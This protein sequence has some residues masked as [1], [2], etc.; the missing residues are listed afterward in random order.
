MIITLA[1]DVKNHVEILE[2]WPI[3][4]E[5]MIFFLEREA[6]VL[7]RVCISFSKVGI[8]HAPRL[9]SEMKA[10]SVP[11]IQLN[12]SGYAASARARIMNW[13]AV[14]SGQQ[15]VDIDY[16]NY[17]IRFHAENLGEER[18]IPIKSFK[19]S[20]D[21]ALNFACDFEQIGRAFCVGPISDDRI[22]STSHF[23][24]G[25]IAFGAGRYVDSYNNM[26]LFLETRYCDG[27]TK[28]AQQIELLSKEKVF[29]ESLM[30]TAAEF[31]K[32]SGTAQLDKFD[33]F[34][35]QD[36]IRE[37][38]KVLV[39]LRGNLRHHS[40]KSPSRWDPNKQSEH[41]MAARFLGAVVGHIVNNESLSD[42]Y[43][44]S[45][46]SKF[47]EIAVSTGHE[48]RIRLMT[49][50]LEKLRTLSLDMSYPTTVF[51]S[52]LCLA[53]VRS[54][55]EACENEGQL[56]DTVRFEGTA[57]Q[58]D[59]E[60]LS[61]DFGVWAYTSTRSIVSI[62]PITAIRCSFEH[63]HSGGITKHEFMIPFGANRLTI[64]DVWKLLKICFDHI[65]DRD[66][67]TRIMQ[68]KLFM[69][70]SLQAIVAYRVGIQVKN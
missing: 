67:T 66:P 44:P 3:K 38:V 34:K 46:L 18:F 57:K 37:K 64:P 54:A 6:N 62:T 32:L 69:K 11:R 51:S 12:D 5:G 16:D 41:E 10:D 1:F 14:V 47:R 60:L 15:I 31:M 36:G 7:K 45:V 33:L 58:A 25:R 2:S 23:R 43:A 61:L 35:P 53:A 19:S 28:T 68:L 8:E 20:V 65:E 39:L 56:D 22:E 42:I 4:I 59:L 70:D 17:E 27:K 63:Y 26:F 24:E 9:T 40:L 30:R 48:T 13:Q 49:H 29:C 21:Q 50:R 52:Q 55:I